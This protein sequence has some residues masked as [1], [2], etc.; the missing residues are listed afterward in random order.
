MKRND[1]CYCHYILCNML[2]VKIGFELT[3]LEDFRNGSTEMCFYKR[4]IAV[5]V[6]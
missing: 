5:F 1:L 6:T 3:S 2:S 4:E